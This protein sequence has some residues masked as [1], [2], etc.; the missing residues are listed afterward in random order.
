MEKEINHSNKPCESAITEGTKKLRFSLKQ[1]YYIIDNILKA[2]EE[3]NFNE[4]V[5]SWH[6]AL[7]DAMKTLKQAERT[8]TVEDYI[9]CCEY[10]LRVMPPLELHRLKI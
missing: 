2:H 7:L 9:E 3:D 8:K 10:L 5:P 4:L 1:A 6:K